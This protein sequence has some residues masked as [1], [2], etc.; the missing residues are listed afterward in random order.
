MHFIKQKFT[1]NLI[2]LHFFE[3]SLPATD[4]GKPEFK[5]LITGNKFP[6]HE[7]GFVKTISLTIQIKYKL[8]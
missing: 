6:V 5:N 4:C 1:V 8:I 7:K 2:Y 3:I